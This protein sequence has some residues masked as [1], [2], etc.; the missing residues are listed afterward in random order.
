MTSTSTPPGRPISPTMSKISIEM[1]KKNSAAATTPGASSGRTMRRIV[2]ARET[3]DTQAASSSDASML[4]K[5]GSIMKTQAGVSTTPW[6]KHT[7][8]SW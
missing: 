8:E 6:R 5:A 7:H 3:P 4:R 1:T 2:R